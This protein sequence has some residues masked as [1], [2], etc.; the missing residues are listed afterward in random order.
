MERY[1]AIGIEMTNDVMVVPT[2]A[3]MMIEAAETNVKTPARTMPIVRA[4]VPLLDWMRAVKRVPIKNP[5]KRFP[6]HLFM[7]F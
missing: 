3:P 1:S 5:V 2:F 4:V 6:R 7:I